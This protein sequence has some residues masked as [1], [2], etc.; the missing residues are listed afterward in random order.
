MASVDAMSGGVEGADGLKFGVRDSQPWKIA[1]DPPSFRPAS[2][3]HVYAFQPWI[4]YR[5]CDAALNR[6]GNG[7]CQSRW[8]GDPLHPSDYSVRR[9]GGGRDSSAIRQQT[10][11]LRLT[12]GRL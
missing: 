8:I 7:L 10:V 9:N 3:L 2:Q 12:V 1:M 4:A 6:Q 11:S 5:R